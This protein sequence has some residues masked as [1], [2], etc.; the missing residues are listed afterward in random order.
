MFPRACITNSVFPRIVS[1]ETIL[2]WNKKCGNYSRE[3]TIVFLRVSSLEKFPPFNS[4]RGNYS[5]FE[6]EITIMNEFYCVI[7]DFYLKKVSFF[8]LTL[9]CMYLFPRKL[10]FFGSR[11]AETIFFFESWGA[12]TIQGRKLIK[13]GN[14]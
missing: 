10:F 11:S 1:A 8:V 4:F 5:I 12:E 3:E 13:G 9:I 7:K 2:F 6:V 14:Y